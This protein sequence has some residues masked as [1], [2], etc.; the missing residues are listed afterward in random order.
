MSGKWWKCRKCGYHN[1]KA[2]LVCYCGHFHD[3]LVQT[4]HSVVQG[5]NGVK[6]KDR[7]VTRGKMEKGRAKFNRARQPLPHRLGGLAES[8]ATSTQATKAAQKLLSRSCRRG[9]KPSRQSSIH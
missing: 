4:Q 1:P 7:Q 2:N 9:C 3:A 6:G 8:L 5:Q